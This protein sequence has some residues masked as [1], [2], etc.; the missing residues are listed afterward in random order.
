LSLRVNIFTNPC[1]FILFLGVRL[2]NY[3]TYN[4][5]PQE[6]LDSEDILHKTLDG[7]NFY[8]GNALLLISIEKAGKSLMVETKELGETF[9]E[10]NPQDMMLRIIVYDHV[11]EK[12]QEP[13]QV[14]VDKDAKL[15]E[16]KV[17]KK[18]LEISLFSE[19]SCTEIP[20]PRT[21]TTYSPRSPR[22][23]RSF[24]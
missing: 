5:L 19:N 4:S 6:P 15:G 7:L 16:L 12:F 24:R 17:K 18:F 22:L 2:R 3:Q 1:K 10:Y 8:S 9:P 13:K 20:N 11:T 23:R 14:F 21:E